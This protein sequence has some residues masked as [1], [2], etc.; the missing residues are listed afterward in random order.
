MTGQVVPAGLLL[1]IALP[2][3]VPAKHIASGWQTL[4]VMV[5]IL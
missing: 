1:S 3:D 4:E 2:V 5:S